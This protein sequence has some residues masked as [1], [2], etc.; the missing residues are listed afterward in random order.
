MGACW[1]L[2]VF[3]GRERLRSRLCRIVTHMRLDM[4]RGR[5]PCADGRLSTGRTMKRG[6]SGIE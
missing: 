4:P 5:A 2:G 1:V 3:E 6:P